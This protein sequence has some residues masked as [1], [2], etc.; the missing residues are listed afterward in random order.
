[1]DYLDTEWGNYTSMYIY[2]RRV[3][4]SKLG[5]F[6]SIFTY[7]TF[8]L[9]IFNAESTNILFSEPPGLSTLSLKSSLINVWFI[10]C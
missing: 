10:S 7:S 8:N 2:S 1:M 6:V 9:S 4:I 5:I 3:F